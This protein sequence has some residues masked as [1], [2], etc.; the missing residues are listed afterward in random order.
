MIETCDNCGTATGNDAL[1]LCDDCNE[2]PATKK[3]D[4]ALAERVCRVITDR[5]SYHYGDQRE[6]FP[7]ISHR[8]HVGF[9][10][11][12]W[13]QVKCALTAEEQALVRDLMTALRETK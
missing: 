3:L 7:E 1:R 2:T 12:G 9:M 13:D 8:K 10:D 11:G 6:D 5:C 4:T